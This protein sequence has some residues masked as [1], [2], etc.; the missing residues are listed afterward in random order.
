MNHI[1]DRTETETIEDLYGALVQAGA[2][3]EWSEDP[4]DLSDDIKVWT[5]RNHDFYRL[6]GEATDENLNPWIG[7]QWSMYEALGD[8]ESDDN[9]GS[10][11]YSET[12]AE[13]VD[14]LTGADR[15]E[16]AD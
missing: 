1:S 11:G 12:V 5:D 14:Y 8:E 3:V 10:E 9:I 7:F 4:Y 6:I 2:D 13:V 16:E 15:Q